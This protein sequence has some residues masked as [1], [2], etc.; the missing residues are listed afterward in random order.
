MGKIKGLIGI[1][2]VVGMFYVAWNLIPPYFHKS[3]FQDD[4]DDIIRRASYT[5]ITDDEIKQGVIRKAQSLDIAVKPD[6]VTITRSG[7]G[8]GIS[9]HYRVHVDMIVHPVD[10]DFTANSLNK[11]ITD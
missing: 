9:V 8:L 2:V 3:Q 10:L 7:S 11:R 1:L 5:A 4:L 6:Q